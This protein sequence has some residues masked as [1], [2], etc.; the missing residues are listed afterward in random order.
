M[1]NRRLPKWARSVADIRDFEDLDCTTGVQ[2]DFAPRLSIRV[3]PTS[4]KSSL[5][6]TTLRDVL[7]QTQRIVT[8]SAYEVVNGVRL[9]F[10]DLRQVDTKIVEFATLQVEPFEEG[11]F[12]IPTA[13]KDAPTSIKNNV[14]EREYTCN[15]VIQRFSEVFHGIGDQ[16]K[17]ASIGLIQSIES[18]GAILNRE[19]ERIEY[20]PIGIPGES[21]RHKVITVDRDFI[22]KVSEVRK[23]RTDPKDVADSLKGTLVAV[24]MARATFKLELWPRKTIQG[25][26]SPFMADVM[27][28]SLRKKVSVEGVVQYVNETPRSIRAFFATQIEGIE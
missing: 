20:S 5:T 7:D 16:S 6:A 18:L 14:A 17:Q 9:D 12:I 26:F 3:I 23:Q 2:P 25:T 27:A 13:M 4:N 1:S 21:E 15:E 19:A 24:D 10:S 8:Y 22:H 11:S 28:Q